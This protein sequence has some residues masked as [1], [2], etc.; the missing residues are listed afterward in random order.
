MG[1][2]KARETILARQKQLGL[3]PANTQLPP[4]PP[5]L[6]AWD[7]LS[8]EEKRMAAHQMEVFAAQLDHAEFEFGRAIESAR[9]GQ[10]DN[11]IVTSDNGASEGGPAGSYNISRDL[12]RERRS[13]ALAEWRA[14]GA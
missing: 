4:R 7:S 10:L 11:T 13:A 5:Q 2:D 1:W 8:S 12:Y 9:T 3:V 14:F 6:P